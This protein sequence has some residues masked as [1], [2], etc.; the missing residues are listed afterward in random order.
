MKNVTWFKHRVLT[1]ID[2]VIDEVELESQTRK[3]TKSELEHMFKLLLKMKE[4]IG[5]D[6]TCAN[7]EY[8]LLAERSKI[9]NK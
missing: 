6:T 5:Q 1:V 9:D 3:F 8:L 4:L 7:K 2:E